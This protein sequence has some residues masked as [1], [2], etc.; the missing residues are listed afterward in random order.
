MSGSCAKADAQRPFLGVKRTCRDLVSMSANDP[1][2]T[3]GL[4]AQCA[5]RLT[6][7]LFDV[8]PAAASV[9]AESTPAHGRFGAGNLE[10]ARAVS[11]PGALLTSKRCISARDDKEVQAND[12]R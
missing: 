1:K 5:L 3:H 12:V 4:Q 2:R 9:C 7:T 11:V 10:A 6:L 8:R